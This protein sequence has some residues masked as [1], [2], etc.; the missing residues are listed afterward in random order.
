MQPKKNALNKYMSTVAVFILIAAT[1]LI[2]TPRFFEENPSMPELRYWILGSS[3]F[4]FLVGLTS[5]R[6]ND[7][8][9]RP[10]SV[11]FFFCVIYSVP[12]P[13]FHFPWLVRL[14]FATG[15]FF[16]YGLFYVM[17]ETLDENNVWNIMFR[18]PFLILLGSIFVGARIAYIIQLLAGSCLTLILIGLWLRAAKG[19]RF[20]VRKQTPEK[21]MTIA[22]LLRCIFYLCIAALY[23]A[24]KPIPGIVFPYA[25][26]CFYT[27]VAGG[28]LLKTAED[29][30]I[31]KQMHTAP[32]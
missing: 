32:G 30:E 2:A 10:I 21:W 3:L 11:F 28:F 12:L 22:I 27:L 20:N 31:R 29:I 17:M 6:S 25:N 7:L 18:L 4:A 23:L 24:K 8:Q 1:L 19:D 13:S 26:F 9:F 14:F 15:L 16:T 5:F